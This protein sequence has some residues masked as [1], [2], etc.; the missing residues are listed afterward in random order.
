MRHWFSDVR[1]F[2]R[3]P[4]E[5][6]VERAKG[7]P[8]A[9]EPLALGPAPF[10]LVTDPSVAKQVL[11]TDDDFID[12]GRLVRKLR[13]LLGDSFLTMG[14]AELGKRREVLHHQ[15][16]RGIA[17]RYVPAM[18]GVIRR[19]AAALVRER[20]IQA[21]EVT[22]P[23]ALNLACVALFGA[24]VLSS[25]DRQVLIGAMKA[26]E[27]DLA[28]EMFRAWPLTPWARRARDRQRRFARQAMSLVVKRVRRDASASSVLR[29]LEQLGLSDDAIRDEILTM[30]L[31]GHHT[32]GTV[33]AWLLYHLATEPG[34]A[35]AVCQ[36]ARLISDE[37]GEIQPERLNTASR[38]LALVREILRLYPSAWWFSREV[39]RP[40]TIAGRRLRRGTSLII[41]P[42]Q[43]HRDSRYWSEPNTFRLDR[44]HSGPAYMPFGAGPRACVGMGVAML[45]L[46]L[47]ALEMAAAF[48]FDAVT[49]Y[50]AAAPK[51]SVTLLPPDM[52]IEIRIRESRMSERSAA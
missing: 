41:S 39:K 11:K 22:G 38:S 3:D 19:T 1:P 37:N 24:D 26:I 2:R 52:H 28:D 5:F 44:S 15:L 17:N 51:A 36:E 4:L 50:P 43:L 30:L 18:S 47:L 23:L 29:S 7:S 31:A 13:P 25:G 8:D 10:F 40:V 27:D 16:A 20:A 48:C 14:S 33:G 21:H 34:L 32:T 42:W 9:L 49:P 6:L 12:K 35:D 45:E 46:Q